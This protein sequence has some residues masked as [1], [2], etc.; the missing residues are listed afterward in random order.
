ML[1]LAVRFIEAHTNPTFL[2]KQTVDFADQRKKL[3]W[4][5]LH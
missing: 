2:F 4:V 3:L 5:F 1:L